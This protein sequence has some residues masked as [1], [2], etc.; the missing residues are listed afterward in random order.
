MGS[1]A[2]D[3]GTIFAKGRMFPSVQ[4]TEKD[5]ASVLPKVACKMFGWL[6]Y[7]PA[8]LS[9]QGHILETELWNKQQL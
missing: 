1:W 7:I 4:D 8:L 6:S 2:L 5:E 9:I 3:T